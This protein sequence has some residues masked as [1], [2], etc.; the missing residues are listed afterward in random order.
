[1]VSVQESF[2]GYLGPQTFRSLEREKIIRLPGTG[3]GGEGRGGPGG[4]WPPGRQINWEREGLKNSGLSSSG[5]G[6]RLW[7]N[8]R[9]ERVGLI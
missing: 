9:K 2:D 1:M 6:P 8:I 7:L 5:D 3:A 4:G